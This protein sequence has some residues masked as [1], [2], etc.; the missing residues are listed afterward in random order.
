MWQGRLTPKK[1]KISF[2]TSTWRALKPVLMFYICACK[3]AHKFNP[4]EW[5]LNLLALE[6]GH[7]LTQ[8]ITYK[9]QNNK[10]NLHPSREEAEGLM[11]CAQVSKRMMLHAH[12]W[13]A[14]SH[15]VTEW[16]PVPHTGTL[17][18][19]FPLL[20]LC[21]YFSW[22]TWRSFLWSQEF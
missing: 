2:L 3:A 17:K 12:A 18:G 13:A 15:F 19:G 14:K 1:W 4:P 11:F 6:W 7:V 9:T 16:T 5:I 21:F 10:K 22:I 20:I 8:K